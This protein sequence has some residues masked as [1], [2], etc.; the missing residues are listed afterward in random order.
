MAEIARIFRDNKERYG[1]RRVWAVLR[2]EGWAANHKKVKRLMSAMGLFSP[3]RT[4]GYHSYKG[5]AGKAAPNV[6][7]RNFGA[8]MPG[9]KWTTDVS[10]FECVWGKAYLSPIMDMFNGEI[11]AYG[12][13]RRPNFAQTME[14]LRKA[15]AACPD[16]RG[17]VFRSDQGWQYQQTTYQEILRSKGIIQSMSRKGDCYDNSLM[18]NFFSLMKKEMFYGHEWEAKACQDLKEGGRFLHPV[19]QP[20]PDK[21]KAELDEPGRIQGGVLPARRVMILKTVQ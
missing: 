17:L 18:E 3:V 9:Q 21:E 12:L 4:K 15:F 20:R 8:S 10:Q 11:V 7:D 5:N 13:S 16:V 6:I 14:M 1:Y 2:R 19:V